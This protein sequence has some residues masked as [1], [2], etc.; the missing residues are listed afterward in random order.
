MSTS[1]VAL[2]VLV[3]LSMIA[4]LSVARQRRNIKAQ[5]PRPSVRFQVTGA[6]PIR[7]TQHARQRVSQ[8]RVEVNE[9]QATL[10]SPD[11]RERSRD[12]EACSSRRTMHT[13][14]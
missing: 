7:L 5:T 2:C 6:T 9:L 14:P 4:V 13:A 12:S 11:A 8:R 1:L 3:A 10:Q